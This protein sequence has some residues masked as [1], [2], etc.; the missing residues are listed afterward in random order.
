MSSLKNIQK[1]DLSFNNIKK[2]PAGGVFSELVSLRILYLHENLIQQWSDLA[3]LAALPGLYHLSLN[4]NPI[5]NAAGYRHYMVNS[6]KTLKALDDFVVTDEERLVD[7]AQSTR[8]R[9]LS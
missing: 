7:S 5:A 9:A 8:F 6:I 1:L 4:K 3:G 2:L